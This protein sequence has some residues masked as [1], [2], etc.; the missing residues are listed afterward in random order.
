MLDQVELAKLNYRLEKIEAHY[1]HWLVCMTS[2]SWEWAHT[3]HQLIWVILIPRDRLSCFSGSLLSVLG[4]EKSPPSSE[5]QRPHTPFPP[6]HP[7]SMC[8]FFF[9]E[10]LCPQQGVTVVQD[11]QGISRHGDTFFGL[12]GVHIWACLGVCL[13]VC[14]RLRMS[15]CMYVCMYVW[16]A[17]FGSGP[18]LPFLKVRFWTNLKVRVWTKMI[19]A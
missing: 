8:D 6:A 17:K 19:L 7:V 14:A 12:K 18:S 11:R 9:I 2:T 5:P 1:C 3:W 13:Y 15:V 4:I 10:H 16:A